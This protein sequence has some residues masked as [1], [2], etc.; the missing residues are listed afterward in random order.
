MLTYN[1]D[2][3]RGSLWLITTPN[4]TAISLPFYCSEAGLFYARKNFYTKRNY[5]ESYL[6]LFTLEGNGYLEQDNQRIILNK[7]E[8]LLID[9]RLPQEYGT[10]NDKWIHYW[11][12]I[13]GFGVKSYYSLLNPDNKLSAIKLDSDSLNYYF[14]SILKNLESE[15][16]ES[17]LEISLACHNILN[18]MTRRINGDNLS[19]SSINI[20][21]ESAD[22]IRNNYKEDLDLDLLID[23]AHLSKAYF[24]RLFKQ[25]IGTTPHN[26]LINCRINKAKELLELSD[27]SLTKIA[28]ESGFTD[29][30][31]FSVR[32][33]AVTGVN[34]GTYRKN[35]F[36]N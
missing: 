19:G 18:K 4:Q 32:F 28:E 9:C 13:D 26:F 31:A 20:I 7:N 1:M 27:L 8:A 2:V 3:E 35:S 33:K 14:D 34:P 23:K 29:S 12:H 24:I 21:K 17:I 16:T 10:L 36:R 5:K 30:S 25:Y 22:Y 11:L 15:N 6:L